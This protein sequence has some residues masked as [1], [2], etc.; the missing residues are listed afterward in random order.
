[1]F[2]QARGQGADRWTLRVDAQ[3]QPGEGD[4]GTGHGRQHAQRLHVGMGERLGYG[5]ERRTGHTRRLEALD[6][7]RTG[8]GSQQRTQLCKQGRLVCQSRAIGGEARIVDPLGAL[9][10][11]GQLGEQAVVAAADQQRAIGGVE[12]FVGNEA[13]MARAVTRRQPAF[14][15]VG[16]APLGIPGEG[17]LQ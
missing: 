16:V 13:G 14:I 10:R 15:D 8:P 6:P 5:V 12:G 3:R 4:A 17:G 7:R 1:V 11:S 2:A 9:Q